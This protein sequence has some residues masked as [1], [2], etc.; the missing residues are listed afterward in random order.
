M[1]TRKQ[2]RKGKNT[3]RQR[4]HKA[5]RSEATRGATRTSEARGSQTR[6]SS[7]QKLDAGPHSLPLERA[8][9]YC[10]VRAGTH[11]WARPP[12]SGTERYPSF[13]MLSLLTKN[14]RFQNA[15]NVQVTQRQRW[16]KFMPS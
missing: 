14:E 11:T 13:T 2:Q 5:R 1:E 9:V 4:R 3:R 12:G 10:E 8:C 7:S 15:K 6:G 16:L